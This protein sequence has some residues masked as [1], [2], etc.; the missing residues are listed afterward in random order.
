MTYQKVMP[1]RDGAP[2][3]VATV[4]LDAEM[5]GTP[6]RII[7]IAEYLDKSRFRSV[8]VLPRPSEGQ[9]E[10][11]EALENVGATVYEI[12]DLHRPRRSWDL[13]L[14]AKWLRHFLSNIYAIRRIL[15]AEQTDILHVYGTTQV[16]APIA[17]LGLRTKVVWHINDDA[18]PQRAAR[19]FIPVMARM[20][21]RITLS[22][23]A[24]T[25]HYFGPNQSE[26]P[27][28]NAVLYST[29]DLNTF[30][31]SRDRNLVRASFG[32]GKEILIGMAGNISYPKGH[33]AF[34]QAARLIREKLGDRVRFIIA[35]RELELW[36]KYSADLDKLI[37]ASG[38][39]GVLSRIGYCGDMPN[40][41][42][43]LDILVVPS[44]WEPLGVIVMEGM[45][46]AKPIV[47][48][49]AGGIPEM[50]RDGIDGTLVPPRDAVALGNAVIRLAESPEIAQRLAASAHQRV[51]QVFS[52]EKAASAYAQLYLSMLTT[53][54]LAGVTNEGPVIG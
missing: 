39:D 54:D 18:L 34:I 1:R 33:I 23:L 48:T 52:P 42:N 29:V 22:S 21:D 53:G 11:G 15:K 41:L 40:F 47:A 10:F 28:A 17:A 24:L 36:K 8:V 37:D 14:H 46:A 51:R 3:T 6:R 4:F 2:V 19:L 45:A 38:L 13:R 7:R 49:N 12:P 32:V 35:G 25:R 44:H 50:I 30:V 16:T 5:S 26:W 43:A 31:A 9:S 27:G 20:S